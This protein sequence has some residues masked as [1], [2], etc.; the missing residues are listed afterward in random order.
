M[1]NPGADYGLNFAATATGSTSATATVTG[2]AGKTLYVTDFSGSSDLTGAT[3]QIKDGATVIWQDR[4]SN[5][6]AYIMD[7]TT[8]IRVTTGATLTIVVTGTSLC[9]ANII[10][11]LL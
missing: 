11:Y 1:A 3:L 2:V 9:N 6:G 7:L 4:I 10:G 8:P 5:T